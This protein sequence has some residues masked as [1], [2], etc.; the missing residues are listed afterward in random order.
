MTDTSGALTGGD[1]ELQQPPGIR[2]LA[3]Y[4][5]DLSFENP[6]APESLRPTGQQPAI[7]INVEL[8]AQARPDQL[9]EV[10]VKMTVGAKIDGEVVF[11]V[12]LLYGGLFEI[13]GVPVDAMEPILLIE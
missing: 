4:I 2:I 13:T 1:G 12:E 6:R 9:C 8:G 11:Q 7:D 5:R 3:Q 10:D